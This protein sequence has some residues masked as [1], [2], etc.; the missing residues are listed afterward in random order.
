MIL[1]LYQWDFKIVLNE[2]TKLL[3]SLKIFKI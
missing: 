3:N 2:V 1:S